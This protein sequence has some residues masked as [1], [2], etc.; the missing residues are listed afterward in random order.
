MDSK[1]IAQKCKDPKQSPVQE[2]FYNEGARWIRSFGEQLAAQAQKEH[3]NSCG[4]VFMGRS[5]H[6]GWDCH[7]DFPGL[8]RDS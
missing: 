1:D 2:L 3:N 8:L 6:F 4:E 5:G 7:G